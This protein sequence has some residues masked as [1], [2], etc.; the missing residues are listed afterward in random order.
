MTLVTAARRKLYTEQLE[1]T[2][3]ATSLLLLTHSA[4]ACLFAH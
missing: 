1:P 3:N 2:E 4:A